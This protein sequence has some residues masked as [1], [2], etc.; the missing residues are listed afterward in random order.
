MCLLK[1]LMVVEITVL[2]I[3]QIPKYFKDILNSQHDQVITRLISNLLTLIW[4]DLDIIKGFYFYNL[5]LLSTR[6]GVRFICVSHTQVIRGT[7]MY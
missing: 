4:I 3:F 5:T 2:G 6:K 1:I 7:I